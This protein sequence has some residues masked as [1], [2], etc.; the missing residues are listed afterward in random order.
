MSE[1]ATREFPY[2]PWPDDRSTVDLL[3]DRGW[4]SSFLSAVVS[5]SFVKGEER[6]KAKEIGGWAFVAT[7]AFVGEMNNG[8][9]ST[10]NGV[11]GA[12]M[13]PRFAR[14]RCGKLEP[15]IRQAVRNAPNALRPSCLSASL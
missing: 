14:A 10:T 8:L 7:F 13:L 11:I 6:R 12:L 1:D 3:G 5:L 15:A 2:G 4:G 9:L